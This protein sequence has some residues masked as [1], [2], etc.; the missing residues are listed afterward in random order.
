MA[1]PWSGLLIAVLNAS[2]F[3]F[4]FSFKKKKLFFL[5][6]ME[7]KPTQDSKI[8]NETSKRLKCRSADAQARNAVCLSH[9]RT[10]SVCPPHAHCLPA[11]VSC[12][13][14]HAGTQRRW[15]RRASVCLLRLALATA[16]PPRRVPGGNRP[17]SLTSPRRALTRS[18]CSRDL[19]SG[20][21]RSRKT[22]RCGE[23]LGASRAVGLAR[24]LWFLPQKPRFLAAA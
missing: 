17:W 3:S 15:P 19:A 2:F 10:P 6:Q 4:S 22:Q 5:F 1:A 20:L 9:A 7:H 24:Q 23:G 18:H 16:R 11:G 12:F 13:V 14:G 21:E 8:T